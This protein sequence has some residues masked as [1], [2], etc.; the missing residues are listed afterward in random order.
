MKGTLAGFIPSGYD[1][2]SGMQVQTVIGE[3]PEMFQIKL[4]DL[5]LIQSNP[6]YYSMTLY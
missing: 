1:I 3:L 6:L 2:D 4:Y 5:H